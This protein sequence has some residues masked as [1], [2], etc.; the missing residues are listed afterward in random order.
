MLI[1][2][3]Y[4]VIWIYGWKLLIVDIKW[5]FKYYIYIN[6]KT[7]NQLFFN[8]LLYEINFKIVLIFIIIYYGYK[9]K[10]NI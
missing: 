5:I 1:T 3:D 10:L 6:L 9:K 4:Y 2:S 7:T 8:Y